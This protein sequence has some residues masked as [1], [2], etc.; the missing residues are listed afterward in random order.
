MSI[1]YMSNGIGGTGAAIA[2]AKPLYTSSSIWYVSSVSGVNGAAPAGRDRARPLLTLAQAVA[3]C[4]AGDIIVLLSDHDEVIADLTISK[5]GVTIV[6]EGRLSNGKPSAAITPGNINAGAPTEVPFEIT[7]NGVKLQN[8]R[9]KEETATSQNVVFKVTGKF[10]SLD[11]CYFERGQYSLNYA[12]VLET[13]CSPAELDGCTFVSVSTTGLSASAP[14]GIGITGADIGLSVDDCVFDNGVNGF[15]DYALVPNV[16]QVTGSAH[17][18]G[19]GVSLLRGANVLAD[20]GYR[21]NAGTVT[22]GGAV[23]EV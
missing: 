20:G 5:A 2:L 18:V 21:V 12:I 22:G 8:I 16:M 14:S 15:V 10:L 6:G 19:L 3:N 11:G 17:V 9:F 13:G 4:A 7:A 1:A 23:V